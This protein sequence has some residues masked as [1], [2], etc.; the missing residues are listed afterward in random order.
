MSKPPVPFI[1]LPAQ[2]QALESELLEVLVPLLRNAAFVGGNPVDRFEKAFAGVHGIPRAVSL[3][4]GTAALQLGLEAMDLGPGAEVLVPAFT[5]IAT[6]A[7]VVRAGATPIFVDVDPETACMDPE[8]AAAAVT[9]RTRAMIPVHLYGHPAPID[10]LVALAQKHDLRVLEDCAQSHLAA[11]NGQMTGTWGDAGAYSFYP[12]KNL[13]ALGDGGCLITGDQ[14]LA[15]KVQGL[16]NHG[17][18][19]RYHHGYL[20]WN[21]RMDAFQAAALEVKLRHLPQWTEARRKAAARYRDPCGFPSNGGAR[22]MSII[23]SCCG[24]RGETRSPRPSAPRGSAPPPTIPCRFP[25]SRRL[26]RWVWAGA[27]SRSPTPGH[28]PVSRCRSSRSSRWSSR[29]GWWRRCSRF[30][31]SRPDPGGQRAKTRAILWTAATTS[32]ASPS[33]MAGYSGSEMSR[34]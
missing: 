28:R 33:V 1:D 9:E 17:R 21:E 11:I 12:S 24:T 19:D 25:G 20:G 16:A 34:S 22:C 15:N 18:T 23:C 7:A 14:D 26:S 30:R 27:P 10:R 8:A 3:K 31:P 13:G 2:H 4:S 32:S 6:A 5:F 29:T